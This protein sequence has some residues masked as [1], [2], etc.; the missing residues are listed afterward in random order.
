MGGTNSIE[1]GAQIGVSNTRLN[2]GGGLESQDGRKK[3]ASPIWASNRGDGEDRTLA[4]VREDLRRGDKQLEGGGGV[5]GKLNSPMNS[6]TKIKS[7]GSGRI[8]EKGG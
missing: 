8:G 5:P 4:I 1:A 6:S 3:D 2:Q 7:G